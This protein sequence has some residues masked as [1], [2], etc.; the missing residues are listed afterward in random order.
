MTGWFK[1]RLL[2]NN[3]VAEFPSPI[4][5]AGKLVRSVLRQPTS[6]GSG[7]LD[8]PSPSFGRGSELDDRM[9]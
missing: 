6:Y 2:G 7:H 9:V 3:S 4:Y 8:T 5:I 1:R